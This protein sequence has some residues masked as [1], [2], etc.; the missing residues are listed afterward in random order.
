MM[1][2]EL[3]IFFM[4]SFLIQRIEEFLKFLFIL[5]RNIIIYK[6]C[7]DISFYQGGKRWLLWQKMMISR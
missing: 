6:R 4:T 7:I 2:R 1:E 5:D 3:G